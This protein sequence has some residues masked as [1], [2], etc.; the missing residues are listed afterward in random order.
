MSRVLKVDD[1]QIPVEPL[2]DRDEQHVIVLKDIDT[3]C[4]SCDLLMNS[5]AIFRQFCEPMRGD[6]VASWEMG[7]ELLMTNPSSRTHAATDLGRPPMEHPIY[8][9]ITEHLICLEFDKVLPYDG[10]AVG[11]HNQCVKVDWSLEGT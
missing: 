8:Y 1:P 10:D 9:P 3:C 7:G 4:P 2:D 5:T 6:V 11:V